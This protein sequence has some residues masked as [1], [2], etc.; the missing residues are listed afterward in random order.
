M[1]YDT[2][3]QARRKLLKRAVIA[4]SGAV[5]IVAV[6]VVISLTN[7]AGWRAALAGMPLYVTVFGGVT[8]QLIKEWRAL[9][10]EHL[11]DRE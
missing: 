9:K 3:T 10:R 5:G 7:G 4:Y 2:Q 6:A 8:Y 11:R 1:S